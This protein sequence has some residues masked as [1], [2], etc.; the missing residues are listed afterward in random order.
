M[1]FEID[2]WDMEDIDDA[3][4]NKKNKEDLR[5]TREYCDEHE[6]FYSDQSCEPIWD[7]KTGD[8]KIYEITLHDNKKAKRKFV[9]ERNKKNKHKPKKMKKK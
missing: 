9:K 7:E 1:E 8:L 5:M 6:F 3:P 4:L 2:K